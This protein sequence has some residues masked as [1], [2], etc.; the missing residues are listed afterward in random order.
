MTPVATSP[1]LATSRPARAR[2]PLN[3]LGV[4]F[5]LSGLAGTWTTAAAAGLAPALVG[6]VLW[7]AAATAWAVTLVRVA[8][9]PGGSRALTADLRHPVLGPFA[10]LAPTVGMLLGAR[11]ALEAGATGST[12]RVLVAAFAVAAAAF[13][14]WFLADLLL[15]D[16]R[17]ESLHGGYLLPTTAAALVAGQSLG[18]AGR[19]AAGH[20]AWG[21]GLLSWALVGAVLLG[22]LAVGP[23]LPPALL[24]TLAIFSAPPAV[25]GNAWF[26]LNDGTTGAVQ[27]ALLGTYVLLIGVQVAL[28]PRYRRLPFAH[29]WWAFT[30]TT[31]ASGT[32]AVHWLVAQQPGGW[33]AWSW[34]AV[35]LVTV[36]VGG[37]AAASA[38]LAWRTARRLRPAA[39][40]PGS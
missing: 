35:G 33:R 40:T 16:H 19:D 10:A 1:A 34:L 8:T 20:A 18:T 12:G 22:R 4:G 28:L 32:Y 39:A 30:F 14:M 13:A 21:V 23:A 15:G 31:A 25:A 29:G 37:I 36:V 7:V 24:P 38:R 9:G 5:G 11:L 26:V 17:V 27:E 3:L 6:D 2:T